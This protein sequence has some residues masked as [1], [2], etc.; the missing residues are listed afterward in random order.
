MEK[1]SSQDSS[2]LSKNVNL[3]HFNKDSL[4]LLF[5]EG[6]DIN[7]AFALEVIG[8][9][10]DIG[11]VYDSPR[12]NNWLQT[13]V[14]R[15]LIKDKKITVKGK[16]LL[17]KLSGGSVKKLLPVVDLFEQ[18]WHTYPHTADFSH[19]GKH[20]PSTQV[21]RIKK[22]ECKAEWR[23]ALLEYSGEDIITGTMNHFNLA[24]DLSVKNKKNEI[25]YINNS[26]TY[27]TRRMF[28]PYINKAEKVAQMI[29]DSVDM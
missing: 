5:S 15:Q 19:K 3:F 9:G 8:E 20:F 11:E 6:L 10:I 24:K 7:S 18:W 14:R 12:F 16:D 4:A 1:L 2:E 29:D 17:V 23:Q 28:A 22:K 26:L 25:Q 27:L 21:K 13:L